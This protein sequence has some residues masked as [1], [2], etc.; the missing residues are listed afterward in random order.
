[1]KPISF[2]AW[3]ALAAQPIHSAAVDHLADI[4]ISVPQPIS[5]RDDA[6]IE[7]LVKRKGGGGGG[8]RGGGG[9]GGGG[10]RGGSSGGSRGGSSGGSRGGSSGS[11]GTSSGGRGGAGGASS[12]GRTFTGPRPQ[13]GG[14][15]RY[16]GG[17]ATPYRSGQRSPGGIL[18]YAI[19]GAALGGLAMLAFWPG[20]WYHPVYYYPY[21][22]PHTFHNE[23]SDKN[24]TKD[25]ACACD[26]TVQC[27]CDDTGNAT[28]LN[29]LIGNGSYDAL[30]HSLITV[31]KVNGTDTI[32]INGT[33]P[34]GTSV[35]EDSEPQNAS[36]GLRA[37]L[38]HAGYWPVLATVVG[39]VFLL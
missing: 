25:V 35:T 32:L 15:S 21:H 24:E 26:E 23:S 20:V 38:Q 3:L 34:D 17:A 36:E 14:G 28:F 4:S 10:S 29:E 8:G 7:D 39:T 33:L 1:M 22:N 2:L 16:G 12:G 9:G 18:P 19:G 37:L 27:G 31:A 11:G 13:Y 6:H 30:N 5:G